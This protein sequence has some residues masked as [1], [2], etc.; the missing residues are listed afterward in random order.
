MIKVIIGH[1]V[2]AGA[3]IQPILLKLRSLAIQYPGYVSA[4][5]LI[6]EKDSSIVVV[7]ST[8]DKAED[9]KIWEKS[10]IRAEIYRQAEMFLEEEPKVTV[11]RIVPAQ[12]WV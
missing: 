12:R 6:G 2:K 3:D 11:Y 1:K 5:N 8:W 4:E 9:W 10:R 7:I